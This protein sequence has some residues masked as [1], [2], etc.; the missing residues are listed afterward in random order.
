M[1]RDI[2]ASMA[3]E[4]DRMLDSFLSPYTDRM[5]KV[6]IKSDEKE[7]TVKAK[8]AGYD[9]D[10]ISVFVDGHV[11]HIRGEEEKESRDREKR[12]YILKERCVSSFERSFTLPEDADEERL[13]ASCRKGI[14]TITVPRKAKEEAKK[15]E[16]KIGR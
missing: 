5:P 16:V 3:R 9:K 13:E 6:D 11:L 15:I 4:M 1:A 14:L 8:V 10:S 7:Y 12:K 2:A